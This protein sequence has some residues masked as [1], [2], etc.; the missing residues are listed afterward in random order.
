[1][2]VINAGARLDRLPIARFH[3]RLLGLIGA[4][5][6]LDTFEIYLQG[7]VLAALVANGWS[8]PALNANFISATFAGMVLGAWFAGILG[9]RF[10]RRYCYQAN[11]LVFGLASLAG[12]AAPSIN[13]LI[14]ARFV[15]GVGLGA[16]IVAGYVMLTEFVPPRSRGRWGT[17]LAVIANS[18]LFV[19]ALLARIIIPNWGWRWMFVI[20]G[21]GALIVWYLRKAMPESPRWLEA[22][23][24]VEEAERVLGDIEREVGGG[25][26]LPPPSAAAVPLLHRPSLATLL[27]RGL[28]LRTLTGSLLVIA[29]NTAVFGFIAF[30]PTFMVKQ[31]MS[32]VTSLNYSTV[33]SLGGPVGALIGLWLADRAGRKPCIIGGSVLAIIFGSLYPTIGDPL[34]LTAVGF[35]LV[36]SLYVLIAI[37]WGLYLPELFP[38]EVRMRGVGFC[39]TAGRLMTVLT[40]QLIVPLF[41]ATGVAGVIALVAGL[42]ALQAALIAWLG[43]ETKEQPL[44]ALVPQSD[45]TAASLALSPGAAR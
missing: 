37:A 7:S 23:G 14:A 22:K 26:T 32:V 2:K 13:W 9:D 4:G 31:G 12:A 1:M 10:G 42:L 35:M 6:F 17:A 36:T 29:L 28:I 41:A 40:P 43:I 34:L 18:S 24:H 3:Y 5:M 27:S 44:E 15:M 30:L 45:A 20:V 21:I 39:N 11:L 25:F 8:T 38:T 16:E 19:S 33:M